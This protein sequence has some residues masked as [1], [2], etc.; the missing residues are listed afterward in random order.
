MATDLPLRENDDIQGDVLAGFK[1]DHTVL[2][3]LTFEDPV[4]ARGWLRRLTPRIATTRQVAA[5]NKAYS[6]ARKRSGGDPTGLRATWLGVGLTYPG[7]AALIDREPYPPVPAERDDTLRAFQQGPVARAGILG[8]EG[9]S[10]PSTWIFGNNRTEESLHAVLTV[11]ADT[12]EDL[13]AE[14]T[15]QREAAAQCGVSIVFQQNCATLPGSRRGK[16]HFG[17]K[18][19]VSEPG[20]RG[21]DEP[22][23]LREEWVRDHPGTRLIPAGE[24]VV[25]H[26]R[27]EPGVMPPTAAPWAHNGSF[28]VVR[29]L[30]QDVPGWWA[31]LARTLPVLKERK[32]VPQDATVEWL[33]ARVVGRWRSGTPVA[34]CPHADTPFNTV[35]ANDNEIS[36][37]DDPDGHT[38][39]L[40][41]HLRK[42]NPR[43]GL[44]EASGE[45]PLPE[46]PVMDRRRIMRRGSPYGHPF[47]PAAEGPG[48]PDAPRGLLFVSY[49]ADLVTQFE[50]IQNMWMD[51]PGF[52]PGRKAPE[53]RPPSPGPDAMVGADGTVYWEHADGEPVELE[54][55]RFVRTE[56]AVYA[57]APSITVLRALGDGVLPGEDTTEPGRPVDTFLPV[58][59]RQRDAGKSWYWAFRTVGGKQVFRVVSIADGSEHT[60][61]REVDDRPVDEW[62]SFAGIHRVDLLLPFPDGQ[63]VDGKTWYW[64]FH[65]RTDGRQVYRVV[66]IA[67]GSAH[68]DVKERDDADLTAWRSLAGAGRI[69]VVLPVPD[70]QRV[71]GKSYYWVFHSREGEQLY[72]VVSIADGTRHEDVL[73]VP[74]RRISE[75]D[76]FAGITR[77]TEIL[78]V[79]DRQRV[80]GV[81]AYWVFHGDDYRI[82]TVDDGSA[83]EDRIVVGDRPVTRWNSLA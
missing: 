7:L 45:P 48:G 46:N 50:F 8:D 35:A 38:T 44:R 20:V 26:P 54:F 63:R 25:G 81:S 51:S 10:H 3:F 32:A 75:W 1:K 29:R 13:Q 73:E 19:G 24:F 14:L 77:I 79:P 28:Q 17:F 71:G 83:H 16:E 57:F 4:K 42:T 33:A 39:P 74:D 34:K 59:D 61:V 47:D 62:D 2:L 41:S 11:A 21:F 69:D 9:D 64:L 23:P 82:V 72:R 68:E 40:F 70:L 53:G 55:R 58:P 60:D 56:G 31:Q 6:E 80:D 5:F 37:R 65:T 15:A 22:D 36:F 67:D 12:V 18:D 78:P 43:D 30:A 76:S 66:S 49:Q 27:V 52:P